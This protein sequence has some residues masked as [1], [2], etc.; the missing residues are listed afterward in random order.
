MNVIM[1]SVLVRW[2]SYIAT[3]QLQSAWKD[4]A[5]KKE[6]ERSNKIKACCFIDGNTNLNFQLCNRL[7][8]CVA[9]IWLY[10]QAGHAA[11]QNI[12]YDWIFIHETK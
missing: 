1:L 4:I 6:L 12:I 5:V 2:Y 7:L 11:M 9:S 8:S 10:N 3:T